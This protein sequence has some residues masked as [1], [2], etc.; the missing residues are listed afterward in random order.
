[1]ALLTVGENAALNNSTFDVKRAKI[2]EMDKKNL[3]VILLTASLL[4]VP[5][6]AFELSDSSRVVDLDEVV[7]VSQP[8][9]QY[10]LRLQPLSSSVFSARTDNWLNVSSMRSLIQ[11]VSTCLLPSPSVYITSLGYCSDFKSDSDQK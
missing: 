9:E 7:V 4:P 2:I 10:R 1:M 6:A 8:K 11:F 3:F 5:S